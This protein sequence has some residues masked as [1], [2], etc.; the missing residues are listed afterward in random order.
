VRLA[1]KNGGVTTATPTAP[2]TRGRARRL[3]LVAERIASWPAS[4]RWVLAAVVV[5]AA[6]SVPVLRYLVF[7][8]LDQWQV[9]VEVYREAGV[10]IL[11]G[12][13]I[14][15]AMT[16]A[17]QLLPFTYPPFAAILAIPL[18]LLPFGAIGWLWTIA[19]VAAT[20]AIVWYAG[21]RLIHRTGALAPVTLALLTAPMLWLHPVSDGLR[22]G[23]VNAFVVLACLMDLRR[24]RPGVLR[25][26][27]AGVL[28]G[29]AMSI[30]L[31]PGVF[32]VH[33]L[34]NR[35][36][37]EAATAVGTA[38]GVTVAAWMVL[39][40]ASFAFWGGALQDPARLGPNAG[41]SNQSIR[42]FLLR[43]GPQGLPGDILWLALVAVVGVV[44]Y[45]LAR[46]AFR[47]G[48]SISEVAVVGLMAVLLSPV[49]WIHHLHWMVVVIF[50]ILGA[51]PLS[52]R[53]RL[54]AAAVVTGMFLCR[55]PWWGII[56]LSKPGLPELPGRMLQNADTFFS[57][58]ALVL[59]W[60]A[61]H[62]TPPKDEVRLRARE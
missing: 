50:A 24:P 46:R 6:A 15:S 7:W 51:D 3:R 17:P 28:V 60:W 36:W 33:Y 38:V 35:R 1:R 30:K 16:E 42:G 23:Q 19:Q 10:S 9:D 34:V 26:V 8:P 21:W 43:V 49:A 58:T 57:L 29:L 18:A 20:T 12:R 32:V 47:A 62:L 27:P 5:L 52:D 41:T 14:Y 44:G 61:L 53:R 40:E 48:D 55:M 11:T 4:A 39:P 45:S 59:L 31:T 13:P 54:V 22:F 56:W 2:V 25:R 37:K